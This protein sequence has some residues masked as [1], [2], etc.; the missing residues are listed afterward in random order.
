MAVNT[1]PADDGGGG[2]P[3]SVQ[4]LGRLCSW[5]RLSSTMENQ[6]VLNRGKV[7]GGPDAVKVW[8]RHQGSTHPKALVSKAAA[9]SLQEQ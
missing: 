1:K 7:N 2:E 8:G 9:P 6:V 5:R 3:G 4:G